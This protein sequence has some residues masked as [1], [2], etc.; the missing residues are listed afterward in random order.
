[1]P[2]SVQPRSSM[3]GQA[4]SRSRRPV[5]SQV[6]VAAVECCSVDE[7]VARLKS[8]K[9]SRRV[10]VCPIR[11]PARSRRATRST[12][13]ASRPSSSAWLLRVPDRPIAHCEPMERRRRPTSTGRGSQQ[14]G[15][16]PQVSAR[17]LA[18]GGAQ[19]GLLA[20]G[21]LADRAD[22]VSVELG[23]RDRADAPEPLDRERVEEG[24]LPVGID[25]RAG[26]RAC[27]RRWPP[28]RGTSSGRCRPRSAAPPRRAP[29]CA[30]SP[31]SPRADR[32]GAAVR[33]RR[34]T[35]R[36][37]RSPRPAASCRR[38]SRRPRLLASTYAEKRG[39]TT[40][41]SGHSRCACRP[42]IAEWTPYALAS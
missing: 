27:R 6:A 21:E 16:R 32:P 31:R 41:A 1:M 20:G 15:Q 22:A 7:R 9:R 2:S 12:S 38:R 37:S 30:G 40:S 39:G 17:R 26:R 14:V 4:A 33:P 10:K 36:R 42:P 3:S 13:P 35:P 11:S 29:G 24:L 8:S 19:L 34:G 5:S 25:R 23:G 28:W 18:D